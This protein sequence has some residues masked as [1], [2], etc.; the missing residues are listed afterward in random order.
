[1]APLRPDARIRFG[2]AAGPSGL[3]VLSSSPA[4]RPPPDTLVSPLLLPDAPIA[5]WWQATPPESMSE[6][7]IGAIAQR[8]I[9]DVAGGPDPIGD[10]HDLAETY[11]PGDTDLSWA[12]TTLWR[13][14][15]ATALDQSPAEPVTSVE[16]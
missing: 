9:S 10:L 13:G 6:S 15:A 3:V 14:L 8:R 7:L 11:A 12:R 4:G 2:A 5:V 16:V 1:R